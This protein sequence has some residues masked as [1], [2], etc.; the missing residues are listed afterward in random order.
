[1]LKKA[2]TQKI[3]E[4]VEK[5]SE[6]SEKYKMNKSESTFVYKHLCSAMDHLIIAQGDRDKLEQG[7]EGHE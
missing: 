1:M 6:R 4:L 5:I 2:D 3:A 7:G